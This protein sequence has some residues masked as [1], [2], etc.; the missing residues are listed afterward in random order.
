MSETL[1]NGAFRKKR[2]Y[3]SQVSNSALRDNSLSL[4]AKGLYA[5]IQSYI[6]IEDFTLYKTTLKKQCIEGEKAFESAWK[7]L[8]DAGYLIQHRLQDKTKDEAGKVSNTFYYEY[9]LLDQAD[10]AYADE[11]HSKQNRKKQSEKTHTSKKVVMDKKQHETHNPKMDVM[12]NG[13][14]GQGGLYNNTNP[15]NTE[16]N[17]TDKT[18]TTENVVVVDEIIEAYIRYF[19]KKP[20]KPILKK[21]KQYLEKFEQDVV[22][23][24]FE[25]TSIKAKEFDYTIGILN[26]WNKEQLYTFDEVYE[27]NQR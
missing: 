14:D 19:D 25:L 16:L 1:K 10:K 18:T 11:I 15:N 23:F 2:V 5:L 7:E 3:F 20:T 26:N 17:N 12:D 27:Y 8:K 9:E 4:K 13:C 22:T 6:T 21:I 24:A